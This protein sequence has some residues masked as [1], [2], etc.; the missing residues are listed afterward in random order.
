[1][2]DEP[3]VN[4]G[5]DEPQL[6][7]RPAKRNE[8]EAM[9]QRLVESDPRS[10]LNLLGIPI[11][12]PVRVIETGTFPHIQPIDRVLR[13]TASKPW[14]AV[15]ALATSHD[16]DLVSGLLVAIASLPFALSFDVPIVPLAVLVRPEADDASITSEYVQ[17]TPGGRSTLSF[18]YPVI[19][20][21]EHPSDLAFD[22]AS[23]RLAWIARSGLPALI[24]ELRERASR[25]EEDAATESVLCL[26]FGF[27]EHGTV[28]PA[29]LAVAQEM[30]QMA[31]CVVLTLDK[32]QDPRIVSR[33]EGCAVMRWKLYQR[34]ARKLGL[35]DERIAA[36]I[37]AITSP[38]RLTDLDHYL[39]RIDSQDLPIA[40][41][42][43]LLAWRQP[44]E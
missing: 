38:R 25:G 11:D 24:T 31:P 42:E 41:W 39:V 4:P 29:L 5:A 20:A 7:R 1:M 22:T 14:I 2:T 15:V 23:P 34:G 12:G 44:G 35:P 40:T 43:D 33:Q 16:P 28:D 37:G 26:V 13:V 6:R 9:M 8:G 36:E 27:P 30:E 10:F 18:N 19:R 17:R 3:P 21:W 32:R